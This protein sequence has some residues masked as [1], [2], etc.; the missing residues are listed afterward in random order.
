MELVATNT[1]DVIAAV[2]VQ[3][4]ATVGALRSFL[5]MITSIAVLLMFM[6]FELSPAI[7]VKA[8]EP[9]PSP[10]FMS[11]PRPIC[12]A[13]CRLLHGNCTLHSVRL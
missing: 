13:I 12:C 10:I 2:T 11:K 1:A 4:G 8:S 7:V 6:D 5:Q 3:I 9:A